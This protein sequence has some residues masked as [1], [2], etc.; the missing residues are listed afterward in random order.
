MPQSW[1]V[2]ALTDLVLK[3]KGITDIL[4]NIGILLLFAI[5][6]FTAGAAS[7]RKIAE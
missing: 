3:N 1:A 7:L 2:T 4:P 5:V 6:F